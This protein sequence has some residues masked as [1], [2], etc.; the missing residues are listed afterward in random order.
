MKV[1]LLTSHASMNYGG[2]L[3]AYALQQTIISLGFDCEIINYKPHVH[4][5]R[6][7]PIQF[8]TQRKD[9]IRKGFLG[10][11]NY[12]ALKSRIEKFDSFRRSY[13]KLG[14]EHTVT[15]D[16]LPEEAKRYDCLCVGSDQLWNL[17]QKD[18]ENRV[19]MLDFPYEGKKIS[20]A[21]SFG[22]GLN[23]KRESIIDSLPLIQQFSAVSV[24]EKEG[25]DFLLKNGIDASLVLDPT[26][27][28]NTEFWNR[29][30]RKKQ[31]IE[32]EYI[33][34]YGFENAYQKYDDL[35]FSGKRL[36]KKLGL[37]VINPILTPG[38]SYAGFRNFYECGPVEF[39]NLVDHASFIVTNSFH[40]SIFSLLFSRP[41]ISITNENGMIDARKK[42][43]FSTLGVE[44]HIAN[45]SEK[46]N[47]DLFQSEPLEK[48]NNSLYE[49]RRK[50]T[51][52][53]LQMLSGVS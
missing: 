30:K 5:L 49:L 41:F 35:V 26:L 47:M 42:T 25:L 27:M 33:L 6:K 18:N 39:L 31:Q 24:R 34:I 32:G 50:S 7:H 36:S 13:F 3:Q 29:F 10:I 16:L 48:T 46:W 45:P 21:I 40:G 22:D 38:L 51:N 14:S 53:L 2:L 20:Y 15:L 28:V 8:L 23:K 12:S 37:P 52:F 19:Y 9:F 1:G 17:N 11:T 4:D 44:N 43:L